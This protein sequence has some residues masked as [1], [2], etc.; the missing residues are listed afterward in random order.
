MTEHHRPSYDR[1]PPPLVMCERAPSRAGRVVFF[2]GDL[3]VLEAGI[4]REM[5]PR[6]VLFEPP[7]SYNSLASSETEA[8]STAT[9]LLER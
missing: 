9:P 3:L 1:T 4:W 2:A 8:A 5:A 6:F 7:L